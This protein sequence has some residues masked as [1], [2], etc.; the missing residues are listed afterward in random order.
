MYQGIKKLEQNTLSSILVDENVDCVLP[1]YNRND[2][3]I[4]IVHLGLGAF[5]RSHQA[6]FTEQLLN[7][8]G[9]GN[10]GICGVS[11]SNETLQSQLQEQDCLYTSAILDVENSFQVVGGLKEVLVVKTQL[12]K[13]LE[14]LLNGSTKIVSLTVTEKGYCLNG[15]GLLDET[16]ADIV[17]D[18]ANINQPRTAI[19]LLVAGLNNRF[20]KG[21]ASFN[22]I[23]CDNLPNNGEKLKSAV[24]QFAQI[25]SPD[26]A[27]WIGLNTHFPN[28]MV[29]C[30]T[31]RTEKS[32]I[33]LIKDNL[34]YVDNAPVQREQFSQWVIESCDFERPKWEEV[35]VIFTDNVEV[36]ENAKLRIL[37]GMHSALA[38][39][40]ILRGYDTVYEAISDPDIK[41][42]LL[43]LIDNEVLPTLESVDG[44]DLY[45]YSRD[46]IARF[47]NPKIKHALRQIACDGS[48]KIPV[49]VLAPLAENMSAGRKV[50]SLVV[51]VAA[52]LRFIEHCLTNNIEIHDP[53]AGDF[54]NTFHE[55]GNNTELNIEKFMT[56]SGIIPTSLQNNE[57]FISS[58]CKR[59]NSD[60]AVY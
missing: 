16:S 34:G 30:I 21:V 45:Q 56:I 19:G 50:N 26:L 53:R 51:V 33:D 13:V 24:L 32:T 27:K 37:N 60:I 31:P 14:R 7:K 40:G 36:F 29:D 4:G 58:V 28:T 18:L 46:I 49:R 48:I 2:L 17:H 38:Y 22:V 55:N 57:L 41:A 52:W 25:I 39:I 59:Y 5:H 44:L 8:L 23:A 35:G 3:G 9:G 12:E 1:K 54:K 20:Q 47:E 43:N 10:W 6:M 15:D 42:F 11:F